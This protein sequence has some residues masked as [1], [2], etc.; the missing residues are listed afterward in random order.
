MRKTNL[1]QK[2]SA[3]FLAT[4]MALFFISCSSN[5]EDDYD[6]GNWVES[7]TFDGNS[8]ANSVSFTIGTKGYLVTGYDG[9]DYLAD[10]WEYNS[11]SD[12]WV[13][14]ASFP[15][16]ARSGAVGFTINGKGYLGTGFDGDNE[17]KDFWEYNPTTDTWTQKAD[18][19]GTARYGAIGF[20]IGNDGYI[21]TGY[22]G[23]EQKD[24]WKYNVAADTWEQSVGFGG[25][26][27][28]NASVFTINNV[29]YIGL[30]IH[31]G[32]YEE[33][34]YS[35]DGN[36][37]TRLTDLDDDDDD[38][39]DFEILLSS[40]VG[41]SLNGKGY[42]TTGISGAITTESWSYDPTTDT[43]EE[44]PAFEGSARQ[45]ASAFTFADKAFV[46]MGRSGS[47][48][49]DDVWEFRPDELE[50]EDD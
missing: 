10:T 8:R 38:D 30:G 18:F 7:S 4:L 23:S 14:R 13:Q 36:N 42:I 22:D 47:Y 33:D 28:Q 34:F 50:N 24:F 1:I 39:D 26:K 32:A 25:E 48:Y 19:G 43:W 17:L 37:W 31:N 46:L 45:N 11:D 12:F 27:R 35:Y 44:L 16:I 21:G 40:G 6:Y 20:S 49:F 3:F 41:F 29:A 5:E 9:D 2:S 15:G